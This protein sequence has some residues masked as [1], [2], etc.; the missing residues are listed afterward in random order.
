MSL[1][2]IVDHEGACD[3]AISP[4]SSIADQKGYSL[5]TSAT[6]Y[7]L[8]LVVL[9]PI[10]PDRDHWCKEDDFNLEKC[11][12]WSETQNRLF[13]NFLSLG[14]EFAIISLPGL[15]AHFLLQFG[16]NRQFTSNTIMASQLTQVSFSSPQVNFISSILRVP[17][18]TSE[19]SLEMSAF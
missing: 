16:R 3:N 10:T 6:S 8:F 15:I 19:I 17:Q 1:I 11:Q 13:L 14:N 18:K 2:A 5:D 12:F 4:V 7:F 9:P